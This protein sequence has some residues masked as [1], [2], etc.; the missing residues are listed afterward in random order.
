M[1]SKRVKTSQS[2]YTKYFERIEKNRAK[3]NICEKVLSCSA[4]SNL[5][6]HLKRR[7]PTIDVTTENVTEEHLEKK[8]KMEP[9]KIRTCTKFS[10]VW[11][12][13]E[14]IEQNR[15]KCNTC[16]KVLASSST[17]NLFKH[18]NRRHPGMIVTEESLDSSNQIETFQIKE[19]FIIQSPPPSTDFLESN[20]FEPNELNASDFS[21][22]TNKRT[23]A[24]WE[25]FTNLGNYH[26]ECLFCKAPLSFKSSISNLAKHLKTKHPE[27]TCLREY[28][29]PIKE[30]CSSSSTLLNAESS[31]N[32]NND[33]IPPLPKIRRIDYNASGSIGQIDEDDLSS[34]SSYSSIQERKL[35]EIDKHIM[36]LFIKDFHSLRIIDD[37]GFQKLIKFAFPDYSIPNR[38]DII[39]NMHCGIPQTDYEMREAKSVCLTIDSWKS[40]SNISYVTITAHYIIKF[41]SKKKLIGIVR[42]DSLKGPI[43][44]VLEAIYR[45]SDV[46]LDNLTLVVSNNSEISEAVTKHYEQFNFECFAHN[47]NNM[48]NETINSHPDITSRINHWK[49]IQSDSKCPNFEKETMWISVYYILEMFETERVDG[50]SDPTDPPD[51]Y[52][53]L[54]YI[55]KPCMEVLK[56]INTSN[57]VLGSVVIPITLGLKKSLENLTILPVI[58][59]FWYQLLNE[60]TKY[61]DTL[62]H[63][64]VFNTAMFLD[65]RFK[66][67][68]DDPSI[69][70]LTK[71]HVTELVTNLISKENNEQDA[72]DTP[73]MEPVSS[74]WQHYADTMKKMVPKIKS[75]SQAS[76]EVDR[77][78]ADKVLLVTENA[79]PLDWW[80]EREL[81][82]PY[83]SQLAAAHLNIMA[84]CVP[85]DRLYSP[86]VI[87]RHERKKLLSDSHIGQILYL[88]QNSS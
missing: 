55:L 17:S 75:E 56:E 26:A 73:T 60:V 77:Y 71:N 84:S 9:V 4:L 36:D 72:I 51:F 13:Y 1:T 39:R 86:S 85:G 64:Q 83:L 59:T 65:P 68:F 61:Y 23:S 10:N 80:K 24:I 74:L 53:N 57:Y 14:R 3:C 88:N 20:G 37:E 30:F 46:C 63:N 8:T 87:A 19:E 67:Y 28:K 47:L 35:S 66:L 81:V 16:G 5:L 70:E 12:Y 79:S 54:F 29:E 15:V 76:L 25:Y 40:I 49:T 31:T 18:L 48:I 22:K 42:P 45:G 34:E 33:E 58:E 27:I 44:E 50:N 82:Y 6:K 21:E 52:E 43:T 38:H 7:H 69:A 62:K 11:K 41:Q 2:A 78:L 32:L